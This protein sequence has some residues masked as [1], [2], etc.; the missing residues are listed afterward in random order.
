MGVIILLAIGVWELLQNFFLN[1]TVPIIL[2]VG[3]AAFLLGLI[4]LLVSL[5]RE[6]LFSRAH[7]RYEEVEL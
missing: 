6:R 7:D 2:K 5:I 3:L 1:P 4:I